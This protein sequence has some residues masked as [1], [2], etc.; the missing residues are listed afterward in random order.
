MGH[1]KRMLPIIFADRD[2][3]LAEATIEEEPS[4]TTVTIVVEGPMSRYVS[5]YLSVP[6]P[7]GLSFS[8]IPVQARQ[9][10][11]KEK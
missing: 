10:H 7:I 2:S 6:E 11:I 3:I 5:E 8:G 9:K 4:R 1:T